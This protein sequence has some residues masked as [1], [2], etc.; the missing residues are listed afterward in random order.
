MNNIITEIKNIL[1]GIISRKI[2]AE[3]WIS[4]LENRLVE[5]SAEE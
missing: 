3:E 1:E 2:E 5:I 4:E